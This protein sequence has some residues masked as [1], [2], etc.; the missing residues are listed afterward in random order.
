MSEMVERIARAICRIEEGDIDDNG[1][2]KGDGSEE[3]WYD[4]ELTAKAAIEAM[5]VPLESMILAADRKADSLLENKDEHLDP[6]TTWQIMI[7]AALK[8]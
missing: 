6:Y 2:S 4:Y 1:F 7:D 5:R 3:Y 8:G